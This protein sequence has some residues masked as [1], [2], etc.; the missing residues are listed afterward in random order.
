[1][2]SFRGDVSQESNEM[3]RAKRKKEKERKG[4]HRESDANNFHP[5]S[6]AMN[7]ICTSVHLFSISSTINDSKAEFVLE[8]DHIENSRA[9][10]KNIFFSH[11]EKNNALE[12]LHVE[13]SS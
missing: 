9:K 2:R 1:M 8:A 6:A 10:C 13:E 7:N 11:F 5:S 4:D 3:E 12:S